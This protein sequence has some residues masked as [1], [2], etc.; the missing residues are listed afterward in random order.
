[1]QHA[2]YAMKILEHWPKIIERL[3]HM[4]THRQVIVR[5][6]LQLGFECANLL[7][8]RAVRVKIIQADFA[9][10]DDRRPAPRHP[11]TAILSEQPLDIR[12]ATLC[13]MRMHAND[14][15]SVIVTGS[16]LHRF[17]RTPL[18]RADTE[19]RHASLK[20]PFI[21]LLAT[22]GKKSRIVQM[23]MRID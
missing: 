23:T 9:D 14:C 7:F 18:V 17:A 19:H 15:P 1:M 20:R 13:F 22:F 21:H 2:A 8:T 5:R 3:A 12:P 11:S 6:Q 4:K 10:T 16:K